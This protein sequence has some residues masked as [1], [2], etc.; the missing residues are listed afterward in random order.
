MFC[1]ACRLPCAAG[2]LGDECHALGLGPPPPAPAPSGGH[3]PSGPSAPP[4]GTKGNATD[5]SLGSASLGT[6]RSCSGFFAAIVDDSAEYLILCWHCCVHL[7]RRR[8]RF[9][10]K[11]PAAATDAGLRRYGPGRVVI[12]LQLTRSFFPTRFAA[13]NQPTIYTWS[14]RLSPPRCVFHTVSFCTMRVLPKL[15]FRFY[16]LNLKYK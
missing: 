15:Y 2:F 3:G 16:S 7:D 4:S 12:T 1:F 13:E 5:D 14:V 6:I 9:V 11:S 8:L 10:P